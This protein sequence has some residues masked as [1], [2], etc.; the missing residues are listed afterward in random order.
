[1]KNVMNA[2][3]MKAIIINTTNTY[4]RNFLVFITS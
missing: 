3:R 2:G 1:L 4:C